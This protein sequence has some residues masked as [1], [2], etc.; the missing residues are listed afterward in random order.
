MCSLTSGAWIDISARRE[1][2]REVIL[3][4]GEKPHFLLF[5]ICETVFKKYPNWLPIFFEAATIAFRHVWSQICIFIR[6]WTQILNHCCAKESYFA[7][8]ANRLLSCSKLIVRNEHAI[9]SDH[10]RF[11]YIIHLNLWVLT[12]ECING[13]I[14]ML[15]SSLYNWKAQLDFQFWFNIHEMIF[16]IKNTH[17]LKWKKQFITKGR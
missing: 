3:F 8:I 14:K 13:N 17:L 10:L 11:K 16:T 6:I 7:H 15:V 9:H 5:Q 1:K 4:T 12:F 2:S